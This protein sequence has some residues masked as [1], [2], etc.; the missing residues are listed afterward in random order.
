[1]SD[2]HTENCLACGAELEYRERAALSQCVICRGDFSSQMICPEG[3]FVCDSCHGARG[4]EAM[5][6]VARTSGST[7]PREIAEQMMKHPQVTMHGPEHHAIVAASILA[8]ARNAGDASDEQLLEGVRR[9]QATP[10]GMCGY[11]GV[12]GS[13]AGAGIAVS[14]L[15]GSTPLKPR[16]KRV[17]TEMSR[18]VMDDLAARPHPRCCKLSVRT[19]TDRAARFAR[20]RLGISLTDIVRQK[21][22]AFVK[23]NAE[24]EQENCPYHRPQRSKSTGGIKTL[25]DGITRPTLL[26]DQARVRRNIERMVAKAEG[27]GV[28]LRP[29]FKTHQSA[30]IGE[31]FRETGVRT[32]TVSSVDMA[33]YFADAGWTD[34]TLAFPFNQRQL[35]E[36]R[37]L[38]RRIDLGLLVDD[39]GAA[40]RLDR[41]LDTPVRVWIKVDT[42]YGRAGITWEQPERI[43]RL[44]SSLGPDGS[45]SFAGL[46]THAGHS[47]NASSREQI[48]KIHG[49]TV[50]RIRAV[51]DAVIAAGIGSCEISIGDTPCC[52]AAETFDGVDEVRPGNFVFYDLTQVELGSCAGQDI[53][54]AVAC[55]VVAVHPDR[56]RLVLYGGA[57]HLSKDSLVDAGG[58]RIYGYLAQTDEQG[59]AAPDHRYPLISIS[60]EHG[61]VEADPAEIERF[62][63]G[64]IALVLPVHSCLTAE[65]FDEYVTLE[66]EPIQ[67]I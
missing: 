66:G 35:D 56:R 30:K 16:E 67:R 38:A 31:W 25:L 19:A 9:A 22:C 61:V 15:T 53:A 14:I 37:E 23:R 33:R 4:I 41:Q 20:E 48:L 2:N 18:A 52:S 6:E 32:I 55:P 5:L 44:A 42:G 40:E 10:G 57:I 36:I 47:Y 8:A 26:V 63:V 17:A 1:M 45:A 65:M 7:S 27:A 39:E 51:R 13:A 3:H 59:W 21:G 34:I 28:R 29:H 62:D 46:L 64:D 58:R 12:C 49:E 11:W 50:E 60:Q 24:C 54:V 43:A